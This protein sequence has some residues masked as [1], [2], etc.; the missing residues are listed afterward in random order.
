MMLE[1]TSPANFYSGPSTRASAMA[2][3]SPGTKLAVVGRDQNHFRNVVFMGHVGF[4]AE[5]FVRDLEAGDV[6]S[7]FAQATGVGETLYITGQDVLLR[8]EPVINGTSPGVGNVI[9]GTNR[10]EAVKTLG[11]EK[12]GFVAVTYRDTNGWISKQYLSQTPPG[13]LVGITP[14]TPPPVAKLPPPSDVP[15]EKA[16][17][18]EESVGLTGPAI[19]IGLLLVAVVIY[20]I[21]K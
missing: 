19:G 6:T 16:E 12:N 2:V 21:A 1:V 8:R 20:F 17:L 3:L 18:V 7:M 5:P 10:G 15:V 13:P 4:V 9:L 14:I 11:D